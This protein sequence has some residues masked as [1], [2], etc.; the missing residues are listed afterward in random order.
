MC[1]PVQRLHFSTNVSNIRQIKKKKRFIKK[2]ALVEVNKFVCLA[3]F[4]YY[5]GL[6]V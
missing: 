4:V 6:A 2:V 3:K 1:A 5:F